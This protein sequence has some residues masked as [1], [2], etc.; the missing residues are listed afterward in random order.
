MMRHVCG[1]TFLYL[2]DENGMRISS[3]QPRFVIFV[4]ESQKKSGDESSPDESSMIESYWMLRGVTT[5]STP[6]VPVPRASSR[7]PA[8]SVTPFPRLSRSANGARIAGGLGSSKSKA[9]YRNRSSK[10]RYPTFLTL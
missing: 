2:I 4:A 5:K 1:S 6:V 8:K 7:R 10:V 3:V 9:A